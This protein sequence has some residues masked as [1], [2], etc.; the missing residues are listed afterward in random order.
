[1]GLDPKEH[2]MKISA[3]LP[4][5]NH[6]AFLAQAFEGFLS[7]T[8]QDWELCVVDDGST[9]ESWSIIER[10]LQ[11]DARIVAERLPRN[12]GVHTAVARCL[13][14]C[15]GEVLC[16]S[17]ADDTISHPRFFEIGV[18][19]LQRFPQAA[20]A[21]APAAILDANDD[22]K[23]GYMGSYIPSRRGHDAM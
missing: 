1:M 11:K 19:A 13:E 15:T 3:A 14:L 10:Y 8:Y 6:A 2:S 5:F 18:A 21:Y 23:L 20:V 22:R 17:A 4:N 16:P 12:F 9:D 7:Q